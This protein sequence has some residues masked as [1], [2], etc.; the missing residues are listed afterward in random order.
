MKKDFAAEFVALVREQAD[1]DAATA[2]RL[3][4]ALRKRYAGQRVRIESA[5][6]VTVAHIHQRLREGKPVQGIARE[7]GCS[8]ATIYNMLRQKSLKPE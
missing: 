6:P 7:V 2:L 8:R 1:I 4:T 3:E 5:Q